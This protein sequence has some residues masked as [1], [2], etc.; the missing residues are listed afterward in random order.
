[1]EAIKS[2]TVLLAEPFMLDPNFKRTAVILC[3]HSEEGSVGFIMNRP[4][5]TRIDALIEDFPEFGA[6]VYFGGPVQT[7]TLHFVHNLGALLD[8]STKIAEGVYW[9]GDFE[10]LKFLIN[11]QLIEPQN[12]RFFL[13]YTGWGEGQLNDEMDYGSWV[14]ADMDAN[15]L[16]K[17]EPENLWQQVMHNK[18]NAFTIIAEMPEKQSWN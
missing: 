17:S 7:D 5:N 2:G 1:M 9:G 4:M 14:V 3:E 11:A 10:K 16:F 13:G 18:G 6:D 15:Y 8:E 12:I